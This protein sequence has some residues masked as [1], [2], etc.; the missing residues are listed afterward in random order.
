MR[1]KLKNVH[2]ISLK[3]KLLIPF[4]FLPMALILLLVMWSIHNQHQILTMQEED[5]IRQNYINFRQRIKLR[6]NLNMALAELVALNPTTQKALADRDRD[7]LID[8]YQPVYE[9]LKRLPGFKQFHFHAN[10]AQS[11]LRLHRLDQFGDELGD[12]RLTVKSALETGSVTGG[13]EL[14]LTGLS[15][16]GVAPIYYNDRIVGS[17]EVGTEVG[18][19]YLRNLKDDFGCD[20]TVY[21]PD[22]ESDSGV[23]VLASTSPDRTSLDPDIYKEVLELGRAGFFTQ[24][25]KREHLAAVVG[26]IRGFTG[27]TAGIV[28]L[29]ASRSET[30]SLIRKYTTLIV[31]FGSFLLVVALV[32]VWWVSTLFLA[33][34]WTLVD[35]AE[36]IASGEQVPQMEIMVRDEFGTLA[37]ALNKMLASLEM[38]RHRLEHYTIELEARV[39]DRTAELVQSEEKFR[40]LVENIPLVVYRL[41]SNLIQTF[42]STHI[43]GL[44]GWLPEALVGGM[45]VWTKVIH[46]DDRARVLAG[47]KRAVAEGA[48][49]EMEYRLKDHRG[50]DVEILDHAEPVTDESGGVIYM[51]GYILDVRERKRLEE[52]TAKAEELKTLSEISARLAHEFRNPL[53]VVGL[54]ARRLDKTLSETGPE[55]RYTRIIMEQVDQLEKIISMIQK[56]IQPMGLNPLDTDTSLFLKETAASGSRILTDHNIKLVTDIEDRLPW[57]KLDQVLMSRALLNLFRNAAFQ[58]PSRGTLVFSANPDGKAVEI[59]ITYPAGYLSDDQIRHFFYPF[60][61]E[62]ADTSIVDLPLVPVIVHKHNGTIQ[63]GREGMDLVAVTIHLPES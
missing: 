62:D 43:E 34:I 12:K 50:Q 26:P 18:V 63:A 53:S 55:T 61:T 10:P 42:I 21:V 41:E 35:Q 38:S 45:E 9:R 52:Q 3:W 1:F 29:T 13:L 60:T 57:L 4:L 32:F 49:F 51:E 16:R 23:K 24:E 15:L 39:R 7:A 11:F 48:F 25:W 6:L 17:V 47:R 30:L 33:P 56:F 28:E 19:P 46:P 59:K 8:F 44:T 36:K 20:L 58:V 5:R 2:N 54:S 14:G 40:A 27:E 37:E 22:P 31:V